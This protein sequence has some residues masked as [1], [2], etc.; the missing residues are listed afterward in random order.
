MAGETGSASSQLFSVAK[1]CAA[2]GS[3]PKSAMFWTPVRVVWD[4]D[5]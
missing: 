2:T 4:E 1:I 5:R 3:N